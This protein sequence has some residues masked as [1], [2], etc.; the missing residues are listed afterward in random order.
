MSSA[1]QSILRIMEEATLGVVPISTFATGRLKGAANVADTETVTIDSKT[2][3]FQTTLTNTDGNV[4]IGATLLDS[5]TNLMKAINLT[6][7]GGVEYAALTTL[8]PTVTALS[9]AVDTLIVRAKT[10]GTGGNALAT[11]E[12]STVLAWTGTTL[13]GGAA[14]PTLKQVRFTGESIK[15]NI[16][17]VKS[18]EITPTRTDIDMVQAAVSAGGDINFELSYGSF[19]DLLAAALC[20]YWRPGSGDTSVLQNGQDRRSFVIQKHFQDLNPNQFHNYRGCCVEG[21]SLNMEIGKIVTGAFNISAFGLDTAG[22]TT[23]QY[24]SAVL[25]PANTLT[26]LNAIGNFQNFVIDAVPY[27]G[28]ITKLSIEVKNNIR[29][30]QCLGSALR[31][32]M[33]LGTLEITGSLDFYFNEPGNFAKYIAGTE[34]DF[35][36]TLTDAAGNALTFVIERAKFESGD[37]VIGGKNTDQMFTAKYRGLYDSATGRVIQVIANPA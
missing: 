22:I 18:A 20:S 15:P 29:A 23:S 21:F 35:A 32:D 5:L 36:F 13:S 10:G 1:D 3:T 14:G 28:C 31:S 26:P 27:S 34:F 24:A 6:G 2:Y 4:Q 25:V 9:V 33:R 12:T 17:N 19:D 16:E 30:R 37:V 7:T 8:H 11:T